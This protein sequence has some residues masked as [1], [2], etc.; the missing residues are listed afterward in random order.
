MRRPIY[1]SSYKPRSI[2]HSESR[3][4][5]RLIFTVAAI[6]LGTVVFFVWILPFII[7]QLSFLNKKQGPVDV[8]ALKIDEA[9]APPVLFIP[10]EATNSASLPISGYAAPLSKVEV[11]IDEEIKS[12]TAT[13]SEGKF[14]TSPVV[15]NLGTNNINAVTINDS[16]NKSLPS[17][18]IRLYYSNEKPEL[19]ISEPA[20]GT[21]IKGGDKKVKVAGKTEANNSVTVNGSTVII[22][23]EGNFET[24][25]NLN[26]GDNTITIAAANSFGN[27]NEIQRLVKFIP[28]EAAPSPSPNP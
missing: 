11:Y 18:N 20:D 10:F 21:E 19:S 25:I 4:K 13:D 16:N 5:R 14:T 2:R 6:L 1:R 8:E 3:A 12:Q 17:K 26:D 15:L 27:R 23:S 22:G 28:E 7:G 24:V 9:I